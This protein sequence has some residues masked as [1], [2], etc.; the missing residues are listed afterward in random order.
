[1]TL[2]LA[3]PQFAR[4]MWLEQ[5]FLARP[6]RAAAAQT[7]LPVQAIY[8]NDEPIQMGRDG[9]EVDNNQS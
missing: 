9:F 8:W 7:P 3:M 4:L 5:T 2:R 6:L 1:M